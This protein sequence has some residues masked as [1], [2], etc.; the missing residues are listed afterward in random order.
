MCKEETLVPIP[1]FMRHDGRC[2]FE[3]DPKHPEF[4]LDSEG[5]ECFV[6][7]SCIVPALLAI[8]DRGIKTSGCCCGHGSGSGVIG[9]VTYRDEKSIEEH[10]EPYRPA[11][12]LENRREAWMTASLRAN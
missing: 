4:G 11:D 12:E 8:W 2:V 1:D 3:F 5:R 6:V 10:P 7:D 9:L